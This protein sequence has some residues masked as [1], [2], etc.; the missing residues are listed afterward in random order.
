MEHREPN[1]STAGRL[2]LLEI[3][4]GVVLMF[5]L[6]ELGLPV[7]PVLLGVWLFNRITAAYLFKAA[8]AQ[9]KSAIFFGLISAFGPPGSLFSFFRLRNHE[10]LVRLGRF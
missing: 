4:V 6:G 3:V 9:R 2:L 10:G 1:L 8:K 7:E 5:V